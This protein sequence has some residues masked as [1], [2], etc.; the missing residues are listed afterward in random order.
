MSRK[1]IQLYQ[2]WMSVRGIYSNWRSGCKHFTG[3][4]EELW[5]FVL[6]YYLLLFLQ[7]NICLCMVNILMMQAGQDSFGAGM[8][9][10][11]FSASHRQGN[12]TTQLFFVCGGMVLRIC[13]LILSNMLL[14]VAYSKN[15]SYSQ[16]II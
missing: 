13:Y 2:S 9:I 11:L 15:L 5:R 3:L 1:S 6:R 12:T 7:L 10:G 4:S 14:I 16:R 8:N